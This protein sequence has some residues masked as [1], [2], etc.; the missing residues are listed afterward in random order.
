[1]EHSLMGMQSQGYNTQYNNQVSF[2]TDS[3]PIGVEVTF[4]ERIFHFIKCFKGQVIDSNKAIKWFGG[5]ITTAVKNRT[6][7]WKWYDYDGREQIFKILR[8]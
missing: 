3:W 1:M 5:K 8:Y 6:I 4:S 2:D 7:V